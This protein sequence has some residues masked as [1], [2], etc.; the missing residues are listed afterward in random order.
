MFIW[1]R[2]TNELDKILQVNKVFKHQLKFQQLYGLLVEINSQQQ[3]F[4][5]YI[6][7]MGFLDK[8][9]IQDKLQDFNKALIRIINLILKNK[10]YI[11]C[12]GRVCKKCWVRTRKINLLCFK[13]QMI[14]HKILIKIYKIS[15]LGWIK[16]NQEAKF[17]TGTH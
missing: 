5:N 10:L 3:L 9:L 6:I 13:E 11:L 7:K 4:S 14:Y 15:C 8:L 16:I 12:N 17:Q 2:R 1:K